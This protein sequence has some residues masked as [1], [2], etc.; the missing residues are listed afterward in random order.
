MLPPSPTSP[1]VPLPSKQPASSI[2]EYAQMQ[3]D[4]QSQP[5]FPASVRSQRIE[6]TGPSKG[7]V[8]KGV[9][10]AGGVGGSTKGGFVKFVGTYWLECLWNVVLGHGTLWALLPGISERQDL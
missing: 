8:V 2:K 10:K 6:A 7:G 4:E 9:A 5:V 3:G 1:L